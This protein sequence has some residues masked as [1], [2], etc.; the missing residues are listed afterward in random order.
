MYTTAYQPIIPCQPVNSH[1]CIVSL[2]VILQHLT[3]LI[4]LLTPGTRSNRIRQHV[5]TDAS[6][7]WFPNCI[8]VY[9]LSLVG[10]L[11]DVPVPSDLSFF[12]W[13]GLQ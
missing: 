10:I 3:L 6:P 11:F 5:T 1:S 13:E 2:A 8:P 7:N 12:P 9:I 4:G